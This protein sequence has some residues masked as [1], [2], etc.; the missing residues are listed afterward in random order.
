LISDPLITGSLSLSK[1]S[2]SQNI[3]KSRISNIDSFARQAALVLDLTAP[4]DASDPGGARS[5]E[6]E[7]DEV[8]GSLTVSHFI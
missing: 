1:G 5:Q 7:V 2:Y 3:A 6:T 8:E 4:K